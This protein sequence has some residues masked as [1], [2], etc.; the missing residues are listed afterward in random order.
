MGAFPQVRLFS[1]L[2]PACCL[3]LGLTAALQP[4]PVAA[5]E[6]ADWDGQIPAHVAVLDGAATL[7][8]DG[9]IEPLALNTILVSGD[10]VRTDQGR[11]EVIF[12][13]GSVLDLDAFSSIDVMSDTLFRLLEGRVRLSTTR[14]ARTQYRID[15]PGGSAVLESAG[16]YRVATGDAR[17][18]DPQ[19]ELIVYRGAAQLRNRLGTTLVRAGMSAVASANTVPSLPYAINSAAWDDFDAWAEDQR[20]A[21]LGY[22]AAQYLPA[23][24]RY[25]GGSLE[26]AGTW[27]YLP[28]YGNVWYPSVGATWYP[29]SNGC[30]SYVGRYGWTWVGA[31]PWA[32]PTHHYGRWGHHGNR[33]FWIPGNHWAP[34][35]VSWGVSAGYVAWSPLGYNNMPLVSIGVSVGIGGSYLG[36]SVVPRPYWKPWAPVGGMVTP[37][38]RVRAESWVQFAEHRGG[39]EFGRGR[40]GR[41]GPEPEP[42]QGATG[43]AMPRPTAG[44]DVAAP[45]PRPGIPSARPNTGASS[46]AGP[47]P[48][49]YSVARPSSGGSSFARPNTRAVEPQ[50]SMAVRRGASPPSDGTQATR[51]SPGAPTVAP[52]ARPAPGS[53]PR[54]DSPGVVYYR[55]RTAPPASAP[56]GRAVERSR[57]S[58][59]PP[60]SEYAPSRSIRSAPEPRSSSDMPAARPRTAPGSTGAPSRGGGSAGVSRSQPSP[61]S[62]AP[63]PGAQ[64]G[65]SGG[66]GRTAPPGSVSRGTTSRGGG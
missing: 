18:D 40:G 28:E 22:S 23:D 16:E 48:R 12:R 30:W 41:G 46:A 27:D 33:W 50:P 39:P 32:W 21:R 7:E 34:A 52:D 3:V 29:Y 62:A 11:L 6:P 66:P 26:R 56:A 63:A 43:R 17:L 9:V 10:R 25:Y 1:R 19:L 42:R 5:Q 24:L 37:H 49:G 35:W 14:A 45:P 2:V 44:A 31:D 13:D 61:R 53:S 36:W 8:R 54:G 65:R 55:G 60:S 38:H 64:S 20:D 51:R 58:G 59:P 47:N 4:S 15:G 57:P